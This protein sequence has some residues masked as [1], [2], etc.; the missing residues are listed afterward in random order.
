MCLHTNVLQQYTANII[1][2]YMM[3]MMLMLLM[4]MLLMLMMKT[5][6]CQER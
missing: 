2:V 6:M 1:I 3:L 5:R 4:L